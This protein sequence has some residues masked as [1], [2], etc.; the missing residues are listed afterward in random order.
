MPKREAH[1]RAWK[2]VGQREKGMALL[3][4]AWKKLFQ[5]ST[6]G[7]QFRL[8]GI[9]EVGIFLLPG[10]YGSFAEAREA[11]ASMEGESPRLAVY[12]ST[13]TPHYWARTFVVG[14]PSF[15][16]LEGGALHEP[17]NLNYVHGG[18]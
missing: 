13:E 14:N 16:V 9:S 8:I 18:L 5:K 7:V 11:E 1:D 10:V 15:F 4:R 17:A 12:R 6:P 3:R 2:L